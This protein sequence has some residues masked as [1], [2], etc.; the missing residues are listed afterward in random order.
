[1]DLNFDLDLDNG[2]PSQADGD[3]KLSSSLPYHTFFVLFSV[4][5]VF[6]IFLSRGFFSIQ[7]AL[8]HSG[9]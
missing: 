5:F 7:D 1:M 6:L 9:Q 2:S 3:C 4:L 8:V